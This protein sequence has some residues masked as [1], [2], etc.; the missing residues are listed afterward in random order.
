VA[1]HRRGAGVSDLTPIRSAAD[2]NGEGGGGGG[3]LWSGKGGR[4]GRMGKYLGILSGRPDDAKAFPLFCGWPCAA[5]R[6]GRGRPM[7]PGPGYEI[8]FFLSHSQ[9]TLSPFRTPPELFWPARFSQSRAFTVT[10]VLAVSRFIQGPVDAKNGNISSVV[11]C[12]RT[13]PSYSY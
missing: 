12:T 7:T 1:G 5:A 8:F 13:R 11:P 6:W 9:P 2:F 4:G 10:I 3:G